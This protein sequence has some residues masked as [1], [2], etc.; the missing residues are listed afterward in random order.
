[1]NTEIRIFADFMNSDKKGRI[2]L[3]SNGTKKDLL[4]NNIQLM[5]EHSVICIV[6]LSEE[7]NIWV[8]EIDRIK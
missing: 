1:M 3:T 6:K 5:E 8:G 2:R 4:I 7:E